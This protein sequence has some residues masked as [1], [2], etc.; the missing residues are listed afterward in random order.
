MYTGY[1]SIALFFVH[2]PGIHGKILLL[3]QPENLVAVPLDTSDTE[4]SLFL[5]FGC[6]LT[7]YDERW[8]LPVDKNDKIFIM[9]C[10]F[11]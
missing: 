7:C 5:T 2:S 3:V 8:N 10:T 6:L 4:R 9:Y 11:L 1:S